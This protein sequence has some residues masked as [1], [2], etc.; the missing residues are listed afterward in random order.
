MLSACVYW[1]HY[2]SVGVQ[3]TL[4]HTGCRVIVTS[5]PSTT[6]A[7]TGNYRA[8]RAIQF[9]HRLNNQTAAC[10]SNPWNCPSITV[11]LSPLS[12]PAGWPC[13]WQPYPMPAC[14]YK[15]CLP[16]SPKTVACPCYPCCC[17]TYR[18][19][20]WHAPAPPAVQ[21]PSQDNSHHAD[22]TGLYTITLQ[23]STATTIPYYMATGTLTVSLTALA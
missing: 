10:L 9:A 4:V 20:Q 14:W 18:P 1:C 12:A 2:L 11:V 19:K 3:H 22:T 17:A 5:T 8:L 23:P 15:M 7:T 13:M 16:L 6:T 21:H